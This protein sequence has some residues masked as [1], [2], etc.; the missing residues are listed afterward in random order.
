MKLH[1][2]TDLSR[3][4]TAKAYAATLPRKQQGATALEY[5]VLAAAIIIIIGVLSTN[6]TVQDTLSNAFNQLFTDAAS[7]GSGT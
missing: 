6:S 2:L 3:R 5:I 1:G 4:L 7:T